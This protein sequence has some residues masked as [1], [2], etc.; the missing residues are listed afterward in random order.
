MEKNIYA[1]SMQNN[2]MLIYINVNEKKKTTNIMYA[3]II[4]EENEG[5]FSFIFFRNQHFQGFDYECFLL[6]LFITPGPAA[7][8]EQDISGN[9]L[10]TSVSKC[11]LLSSLNIFLGIIENVCFWL[12]VLIAVQSAAGSSKICGLYC[13]HWCYQSR[14]QGSTL[15]SNFLHFSW[16]PSVFFLINNIS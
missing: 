16:I 1:V 4:C 3:S 8:K 6:F 7:T 10:I 14:L 15:G 2:L 13:R 12:L 9:L 5:K 11:I